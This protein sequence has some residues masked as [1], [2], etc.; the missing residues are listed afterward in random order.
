MLVT[1]F[2]LLGP[3]SSLLSGFGLDRRKT[4]TGVTTLNF[5]P[6][7]CVC[8]CFACIYV[9]VSCVCSAC[10]IKGECQIPWDWTYRQ[11]WTAVG[12]GNG[13]WVAWKVVLALTD[14]LSLPNIMSLKLSGRL[15]EAEVQEAVGIIQHCTPDCLSSPTP[16][17]LYPW[18][19]SYSNS[20]VQSLWSMN[21]WSMLRIPGSLT[22]QWRLA[23]ASRNTLQLIL[24]MSVV[25]KARSKTSQATETAD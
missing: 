9:N 20:V 4:F 18:W 23:N 25:T 12:V 19:H 22:Q 14:E 10:R 3:R 13:P 7:F 16:T 1:Q 11:L 2:L 5:F 24:L 17:A 21:L 8:G 15:S 6:L